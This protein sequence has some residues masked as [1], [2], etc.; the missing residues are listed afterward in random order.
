MKKQLLTLMTA[1]FL[2]TGMTLSA[3]AVDTAQ[4]ATPA[5]KEVQTKAPDMKKPPCRGKEF[6]AAPGAQSELKG[7]RPPKCDK[8]GNE[9]F[10]PGHKPTKEE[11]EAKRAEF[12][13]RLNLTEEQ[14]KKAEAN[15][16]KDREKIEPVMKKLKANRDEFIKIKKD[17]TLSDADKAKQIE[18][19]RKERKE[20]QIKADKYHRENMKKFEE[21]LTPEQK[22]EFE[23]IKA[24]KKAEREKFKQLHNSENGSR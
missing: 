21:L 1:M 10:M 19:L 4:T 3:N 11:L 17:T 16:Q 18:K 7:Q 23:K 5:T 22:A 14:K 24:E 15:R 6:K 13:K 20:L 9:K 8:P 12:E 2:V